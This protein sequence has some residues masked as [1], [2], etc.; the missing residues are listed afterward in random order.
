MKSIVAAILATLGCVVLANGHSVPS[1]F[2]S[3]SP[4]I[5]QRIDKRITT[6]VFRDRERVEKFL[7]EEITRRGL[8]IGGGPIIDYK[9]MR[10]FVMCRTFQD[11]KLIEEVFEKVR[12]KESV[13]TGMQH[14][15]GT[16]P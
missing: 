5:L 7:L 12:S 13:D 11:I 10:I 14:D 1:S 8:K 16:A 2:I 15:R 3:I 6:D 4:E 9:T